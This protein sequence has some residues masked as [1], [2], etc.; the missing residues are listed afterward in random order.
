MSRPE[1]SQNAGIIG[2]GTELPDNIITNQRLI[3]LTGVNST[4]QEIVNR[5]GIR[6]RRWATESQYGSE[7]HAAMGTLAAQSTLASFGISAEEI[8]GLFVSDILGDYTTPDTAV[9][10]HGR[11]ELDEWCATANIGGACNGGT[12]A[13]EIA[14]LH[15]EKWRRPSLAVGIS[16]MSKILDPR[17]RKQNCLFGD[18]AAAFAINTHPE[19]PQ[20]HA[21]FS[22]RANRQAIGQDHGKRLDMDG[23]KVK[24]YARAMVPAVIGR[25]AQAAGVD[26]KTGGLDFTQIDAII[27]HAGNVRM[28]EMLRDLA[29]IPKEKFVLAPLEVT[30]NTSAASVGVGLRYAYEQGLLEYNRLQKIILVSIGAGME[31]TAVVVGSYVNTPTITLP[32]MLPI[33]AAA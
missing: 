29:K 12:K 6:E 27:P 5:T 3:E 15:T 7:I 30:G 10:M 25:V 4:P 1:H 24:E 16:V 11:L 20:W 18:G 23:H 33:Q 2:Y 13:T 22:N 32:H 17:D 9:L 14:L 21:A 19:M 26:L 8:G 28:G 31:A